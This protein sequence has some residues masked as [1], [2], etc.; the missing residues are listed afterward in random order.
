[1]SCPPAQTP[2]YY[3]I[4]N[5]KIEHQLNK[6]KTHHN[7]RDGLDEAVQEAAVL[8]HIEL[9]LV[10]AGVVEGEGGGLQQVGVCCVHP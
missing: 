7:D 3:M 5:T 9:L 8:G 1:M 10:A 2:G 6:K 4:S